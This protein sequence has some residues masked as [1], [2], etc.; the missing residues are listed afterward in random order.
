[1]GRIIKA[2]VVLAVLGFVGLTG[3]A[4]LGDLTPVQSEVKQ[5]VTLDAN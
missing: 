1:M 4:Y 5:P 2:L 3:Y